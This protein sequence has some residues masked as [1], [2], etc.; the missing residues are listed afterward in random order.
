MS[1]SSSRRN[2]PDAD[3]LDGGGGQYDAPALGSKKGTMD[4]EFP[5]IGDIESWM[6]ENPQSAPTQEVVTVGNNV[7]AGITS[8]EN[9]AS[10]IVP[11]A[12]TLLGGSFIVIV[13]LVLV[14]LIMGKVETL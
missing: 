12:S 10:S 14:L 9:A 13:I 8:A 2:K 7:S 4:T 3:E 11:S 6:S 1:K 5:L